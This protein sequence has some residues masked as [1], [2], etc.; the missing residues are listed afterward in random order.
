MFDLTGRVALVT[1]AGQ[2][3]GAGIAR[4]LAGQGAKVA[5]NDLLEARAKSTAEAIAAAGGQALAVAFDV[6]DGDAVREGVARIEAEL[7][8]VEVLVNNAGVPPDMTADLKQFVDSD[9]A[10]WSTYVDLNLYGVLHCAKAVLDGM[11]ERGFGR[12]VTISSGAG[13]TGIPLGISTYGAGKAGAIG[14]SRHL[15]VEVARQGVTVNCV[16]LGLMDNAGDKEVVAH[17]ARTV[18]AGRCGSAEDVGAAVVYLASDE[19]S[20]VTGQTLGVNGGSHTP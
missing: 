7:G 10:R 9:P 16:A 18:P 13:Q 3:I 11:I 5:V 1:G 4:L 19:A 8:P 17:L 2:N 20:W 12:I 15:A 14:F 6:T